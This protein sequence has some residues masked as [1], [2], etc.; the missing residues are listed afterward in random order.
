MA[1]DRPVRHG[2]R[3]WPAA[4]RRVGGR[5]QRDDRWIRIRS[6]IESAREGGRKARARG[7]CDA[8]DL[9]RDVATREDGA[10]DGRRIVDAARGRRARVR[11][12]RRIIPFTRV[13][14]ESRR[15]SPVDVASRV[16]RVVRRH[17]RRR[18]Q[19]VGVERVAARDLANIAPLERVVSA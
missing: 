6:I 1:H 17:R 9:G 11:W 2:R 7:R 10:G 13:W 5:S 14:C 15:P 19:I 4:A 3:R 12:V 18:S 16:A 8:I